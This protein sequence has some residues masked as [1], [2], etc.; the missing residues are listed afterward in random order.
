MTPLPPDDAA[1]L[2]DYRFQF[3]HDGGNLALVLDQLTDALQLVNQH[4]VYC[5]VERGE[6]AGEP[7]MWTSPPPAPESGHS[8]AVAVRNVP[9]VRQ[10]SSSFAHS[11]PWAVVLPLPVYT[12]PPSADTASAWMGASNSRAT[13]SRPLNT[14]HTR[15]VPSSP[16][17]SR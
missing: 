5:R 12:V 15:T 11:M 17:L 6:R 8:P 16:P 10:S 13:I 7:L 9:A 2:D 14:S 3:G 1:R 4:T